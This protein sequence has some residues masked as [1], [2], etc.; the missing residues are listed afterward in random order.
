[1]ARKKGGEWKSKVFFDSDSSGSGK[2]Y[3]IADDDLVEKLEEL[4]D[5]SEEID[6]VA[7]YTLPLGEWQLTDLLLYHEFA[8]FETR[9]WWWT[10]EKDGEGLHIQRSKDKEDVRD[11]FKRELRL[12]G[13]RWKVTINNERCEP[14]NTTT[15]R[16]LVKWLW[17]K[18]ELN[19]TYNY[20][21]NNCKDLA[22][23]VYRY[24]K[25]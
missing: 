18:D 4:C 1:M 15:V 20:L 5:L 25:S 8:L 11:R 2:R 3:R 16:N 13:S 21:A 10:I 12:K 17:R 7:T 23:R 14:D 24:V 19:Q 9:K 6:A 22:G